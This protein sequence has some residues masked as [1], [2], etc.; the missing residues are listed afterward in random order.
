M[1]ENPW[2]IFF[3]FLSLSLFFFFKEK[4]IGRNS[5]YEATSSNQAFLK[6]LR[7]LVEFLKQYLSCFSFQIHQVGQLD[8][9]TLRVTF[10]TWSLQHVQ[11]FHN[12]TILFNSTI[13]CCSVKKAHRQEQP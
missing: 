3:F 7:V 11:T 12:P 6:H 2:I 4:V 8:T 1:F 5:T 10:A 13:A 9:T